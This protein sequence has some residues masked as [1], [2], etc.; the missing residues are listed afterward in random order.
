[1]VNEQTFKGH[2]TE[3]RGKVK[4]KWGA[5]TDDDLV[6]AEGNADQL[7][8]IVQRRTGE[9][10]EKIEHDLDRMTS[11]MGTTME[12]I[13][14]QASSA[15]AGASESARQYA[16]RASETARKYAGTAS[17]TA[18]EYADRA[19][20]AARQQY[21]QFQGQ[22]GDVVAGAQAKLAD[23]EQAVRRNPIESLCVAFGTGLVAGVVVG[24]CFRPSRD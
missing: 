16:D 5:L 13:R 2:W 23:A 17:E 9:S 10:R 7:I 3:L 22:Y 19:S 12:K 4:E 15:V 1:M 8:G 24:L 6:L 11:D 14:S 21:E 20:D 18:R